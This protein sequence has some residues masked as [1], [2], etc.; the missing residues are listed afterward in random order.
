MTV[1]PNHLLSICKSLEM[2]VNK[3]VGAG[4]CL[5]EL[6]QGG[7]GYRFVVPSGRPRAVAWV[8]F[9]TTGIRTDKPMRPCG[10]VCIRGDLLAKGGVVAGLQW[11][12]DANY[13]S[14]QAGGHGEWHGVTYD[15]GDNG[16][17]AILHGLVAAI[18][19][20]MRRASK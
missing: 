18:V 11:N 10:I 3:Q 2:D 17:Q 13:K 4:K 9:R 5:F 1:V 14:Q 15:A 20:S 12:P 19:E 6:T 16:Y 7:T 8:G